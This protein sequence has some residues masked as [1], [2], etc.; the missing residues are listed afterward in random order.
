MRARSHGAI[1]N[2]IINFLERNSR[3]DTIQSAVLNIK[4]KNYKSNYD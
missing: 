2:M 4:L 1:K 3:L